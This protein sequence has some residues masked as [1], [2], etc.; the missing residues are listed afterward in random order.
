MADN[1]RHPAVTILLPPLPVPP[2]T[3]HTHTHIW[4][5]YISPVP[6]TKNNHFY[7]TIKIH[8]IHQNHT[9][10]TTAGGTQTGPETRDNR[11][12]TAAARP[13]KTIN[14]PVLVG[15]LEKPL[16]PAH[17]PVSVLVEPRERQ[18]VSVLA[19]VVGETPVRRCRRVEHL[20]PLPFAVRRFVIA[21]CLCFVRG[22]RRQMGSTLC[23]RGGGDGNAGKLGRGMYVLS[24][25]DSPTLLLRGD[26]MIKQARRTEAGAQQ[27]SNDFPLLSASDYRHVNQPGTLSTNPGHSLPLP[28]SFLHVRSISVQAINCLL[29]VS[30]L[31]VRVRQ[32]IEERS[33]LLDGVGLA[34]VELG[35]DALV[36][37]PDLRL[38][39][40]GRPLLQKP[41][42]HLVSGAR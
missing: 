8:K 24:A 19:A 42:E 39:W 6:G 4:V 11:T 17:G 20:L 3:P 23:T 5:K 10:T 40:V 26:D 29:S 30:R 18:A 21:L 15:G 38:R 37:E 36:E 7:E 31:V 25:T 14:P 12:S 34:A 9:T 28:L 33:V 1:G 41:L 2:F 16:R 13:Q 27:Q 22:G 32:V 35:R